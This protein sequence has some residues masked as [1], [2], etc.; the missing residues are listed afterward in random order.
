VGGDP[1]IRTVGDRKVAS[2]NLA[3]TE[4]YKDR[5]GQMVENTEWHSVSVWEKLAEVVESY[6]K[7][8]TLIYVE[9]KIKTEK[10]TDKDGNDRFATRIQASTLQLLGGKPEGNSTNASALQNQSQ[11]KF[12]TTPIVAGEDQGDDLPF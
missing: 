7:K 6:V 11:S 2:F 1:Q 5:S 4:K 3:T 9:G 10:Y 8:G 12:K